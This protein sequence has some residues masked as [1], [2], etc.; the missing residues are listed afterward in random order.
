MKKTRSIQEIRGP[1][2][3]P[4]DLAMLGDRVIVAKKGEMPIVGKPIRAHRDKR[5]QPIPA[6]PPEPVKPPQRAFPVGMPPPTYLAP[7]A[8]AMRPPA[9]LPAATSED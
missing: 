5:F 1:L 3:V 7:P 2:L 4:S 8:L 6:A 9:A